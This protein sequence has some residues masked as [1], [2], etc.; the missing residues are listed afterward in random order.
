MDLRKIFT[1][2]GQ[3]KKQTGDLIIEGDVDENSEVE[4]KDGS[5]EILGT[6]KDGAKIKISVSE[7]L[8]ESMEEKQNR[9]N[10]V[11]SVCSVTIG[12]MMIGDVNINNRI[13]TSD[14]IT[15]LGN[16]RYEITPL[17]ESPYSR[18]ANV[19]SVTINGVKQGHRVTAVP[20]VATVLVDGI[21]YQGKKIAIDGNNVLVDGKKI[22]P[23][24]SEAAQKPKGPLKL[25][26]HGNIGNNVSID[27]DVEIEIKGTTGN[28][29]QIKSN[30]S[31]IT[32][33]NIGEETHL[34]AYGSIT[35]ADIDK[36]CELKTQ[37]GDLNAKSL[38]SSV[39]VTVNKSINVQEDIGNE[40]YLS[41]EYGEL[42]ARNIGDHV[43]VNTNKDITANNIGSHSKLKSEY[44]GLTA[45][46]IGNNVQISVNKDVIVNN[47]GGY[48]SITSE[49]YNVTVRNTV[50]DHVT[51]TANKDISVNNLGNNNRLTSQYYGISIGNGGMGNDI[52]AN[53]DVN[54]RSIGDNSSII[55][56][57]YAVRAHDVGNRVHITAN[58]DITVTGICPDTRGFRSSYGRV[59]VAPQPAYQAP[60][61]PAATSTRAIAST[62][63]SHAPEEKKTENKLNIF[64]KTTQAYVDGFKNKTS[65]VKAIEIA[66]LSS[67]AF[68]EYCD[69][70]S[71]EIMNI[72]VRVNGH[73]YDLETLTK[74][75]ER[76][77]GTREDPLSREEFYL[78][79][80]QPAFDL[81]EKIKEKLR[82][83][84]RAKNSPPGGPILV[85][86][87]TNS[88]PG[89]LAF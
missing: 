10:V 54:V 69:P 42:T 9:G 8:R 50:M 46:N 34:E 4:I 67:D 72:P 58:K 75:P 65:H 38:K 77:D 1:K 55:S 53:K 16:G 66:S 32:T 43:T 27:S 2:K 30:Y 73:V 15:D 89:G 6:I 60:A 74:L 83:E 48:S 35:C 63:S 86:N 41:T 22:A 71:A 62:L 80:I 29:C 44:Y 87:P 39:N 52:H 19:G 79:D 70:I 78:R 56:D 37:Y 12:N 40:C 76:Q 85:E 36:G 26:V 17:S 51:I 59:N 14:P 82:S 68:E 23:P 25:I 21:R 33:N 47:V 31:K 18:Y 84:I 20:G 3:V 5:L 57:Y 11:S 64:S 24:V 45:N 28:F 81:E 88:P 49:Y 7:A 61:R 13:F